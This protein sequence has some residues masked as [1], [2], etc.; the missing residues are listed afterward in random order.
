MVCNE[1]LKAEVVEV[2]EVK[3]LREYQECKLYLV[4]SRKEQ[5]PDE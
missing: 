2:F 4:L 3:E 5:E 1:I